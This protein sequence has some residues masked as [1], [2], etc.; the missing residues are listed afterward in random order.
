ML[1]EMV[2]TTGPVALWGGNGTAALSIALYLFLLTLNVLLM[3]TW[4]AHRC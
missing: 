4:R 1:S 2:P 3:N